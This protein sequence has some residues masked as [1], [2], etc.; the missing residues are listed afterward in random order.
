MQN[1]LGF[2]ECISG[3]ELLRE[4]REQAEHYGAEFA[5]EEIERIEARE[6]RF[7]LR[8]KKSNFVSRRLLLATGAYHLPPKIPPDQLQGKYCY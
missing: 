3:G 6:G 5:R 4:G 1:Y 8:G 7:H 2:P